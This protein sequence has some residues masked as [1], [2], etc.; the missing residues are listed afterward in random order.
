LNRE[1]YE[2]GSWRKLTKRTLEPPIVPADLGNFG[3]CG[4]LGEIY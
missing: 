1:R 3:I 2:V 4:G